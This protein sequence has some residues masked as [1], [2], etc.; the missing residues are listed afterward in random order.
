[1]KR[2]KTLERTGIYSIEVS[3]VEFV[4]YKYEGE[5]LADG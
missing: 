3:E 5:K 4:C 1:M 2:K